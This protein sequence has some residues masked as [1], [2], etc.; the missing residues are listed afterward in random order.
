M[1]PLENISVSIDPLVPGLG[2][3]PNMNG[4]EDSPA[5]ADHELTEP[6]YAPPP[7]RATIT[8]SVRYRIRGRGRPMPF[9]LDEG[10][11]Q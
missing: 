3:R 7:S 11:D 6:Q 1:N 5:P 10:C 4:S 2:M 8:V 9:T